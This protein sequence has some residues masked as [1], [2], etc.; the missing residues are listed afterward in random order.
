MRDAFHG[1]V[2]LPVVV[3]DDAGD[4]LHQTA[5]PRRDAVED[6]PHGAS[7][8][9]PL[10]PATDAE[11]GLS[12]PALPEGPSR[13]LTAAA[14]TNAETASATPWTRSAQLRLIRAMVAATSRTGRP[15][16]RPADPPAE[17]GNGAGRPR[18]PWTVLHR[19]CDPIGKLGPCPLAA[20]AGGVPSRPGAAARADRP[21]GGR[22]GRLTSPPSV[23]TRRPGRPRDNA[24]PCG[25][26]HRP[27]AASSPSARRVVWL[28]QTA[29]LP[30]RLVQSI[31]G[32]RLAAIGTVQPKPTLQLRH[33]RQQHGNGFLEHRVLGP[34]APK[35]VQTRHR[36]GS[37]I[38]SAGG[39]GSIFDQSHGQVD[40]YGESRVNRFFGAAYLGSYNNL[41][42]LI[43]GF[44]VMADCHATKAAMRAPRRAFPRRRVLWT[45]WKKPR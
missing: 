8:V 21:P 12:P 43:S 14:F 27:A 2:R 24:R 41:R 35:I 28:A 39:T 1:V 3:D 9:Q 31:A 37:S 38:R 30:L 20:A 45:N 5:P 11:A 29:R 22:C 17:V 15:S 10:R 16:P 25:S 32:R 13:C 19:R 44:G 23:P 18:L 40:S 36:D 6:E 4:A 7:D 34:K 26:A 42:R 33:P